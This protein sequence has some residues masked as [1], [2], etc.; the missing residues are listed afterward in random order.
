MVEQDTVS[1]DNDKLLQTVKKWLRSEM[2]IGQPKQMVFGRGTRT[3]ERE[4]VDISIEVQNKAPVSSSGGN[5]VY[6]GVGLRIIYGKENT[7]MTWLD[8]LSKSKPTDQSEL[9]QKYTQGIWYQGTKGPFP[10]VTSDEESLGDVLFPGENVIYKFSIPKEYLPYLDIQVECTVSRRHLLHVIQP[11]E[12]LKQY[13]QPLLKNIF[14][15]IDAINIFQPLITMASSIPDL[16]SGTTLAEIEALRNTLDIIKKHADDVMP[17]LNKVYHS[18]PNQELRDHMKQEVG[19]H[20]TSVKKACDVTLE[21]LSSSD[22]QQMSDAA[23]GLKNQLIA[24]EDV[25]RKQID[26]MS[27]FGVVN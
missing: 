4:G 18:A 24:S 14:D 21:A 27:S 2:N 3:K 7:R 15:A 26:L 19:K 10:A 20:L 25:R 17:E 23:E 1:L 6:L 5:V 16:G 9:R 22:T 8:T 11:L 12:A 13:R